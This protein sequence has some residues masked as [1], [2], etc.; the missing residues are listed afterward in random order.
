MCFY[1]H[2]AK[3]TLCAS[4][5]SQ[6]YDMW[7][8]CQMGCG[9]KGEDWHVC[10]FIVDPGSG[11]GSKLIIVEIE[12]K[13]AWKVHGRCMAKADCCKLWERPQT[14]SLCVSNRGKET[15][16]EIKEKR[17]KPVED[18]LHTAKLREVTW[19]WNGS[20]RVKS[21]IGALRESSPSTV[22]QQT[23]RASFSISSTIWRLDSAYLL[24][25]HPFLFSF[26]TL[27][28]PPERTIL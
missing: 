23:I 15:L 9:T 16:T 4:H 21:C 24:S 18:L 22:K 20:H 19:G 26:I 1:M 11:E 6:K 27:W 25:D 17:E 2:I 13:G 28:V 10:L 3:Q 12:G 7:V 5:G 14:E 8:D